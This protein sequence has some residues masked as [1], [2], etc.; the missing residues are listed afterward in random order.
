M[1]DS[2]DSWSKVDIVAGVLTPIL[3][4]A[5]GV[6]YGSRQQKAD[7]AQKSADRV[8]SL[9]KDLNSDKPKEQLMAIVL[10][11]REK[12]KH[13]E[14][15][16]DELLAGAVPALVNIAVNDRNAEVSKQAQ[17]FVTEVTANGDPA[18]AASVKSSVE[19][20]PARVYIHIRDE[21]QRDAAR[22]I[23]GKLEEKDLNVPGIERLDTGP[24]TTE[25]RFFRRDDEGEVNEIVNL[26]NSLNVD[27]KAKYVEG[28]ENS[29]A[30]RPK[31]YELW[32]S[33]SAL[34]NRTP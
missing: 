31:H 18:L 27:A 6:M 1:S 14:E 30:M 10:L 12:Q 22:Q 23:E 21:K 3:I 26:L 34:T 11:R 9:V 28:Y 2:R 13:P 4:F 16:P 5:F 8:A 15:V 20:L 25:L 17:Q 32:F 29:K 19:N 24:N 33:P 7:E